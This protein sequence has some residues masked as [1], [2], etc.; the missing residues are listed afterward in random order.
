EFTVPTL[1]SQPL[2]I[3]AGP[4]GNLW[5][6]EH[7]SNRIGRG[8][9]AGAVNEFLLLNAGGQPTGITAG[10]DG[11]LWFTVFAGNKVARSNTR[12]GITAEFPGPTAG[13]QP[14]GIT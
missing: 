9:P 1:N 2:G 10:P 4:D 3:T 8:T 6:T 12:G 11:N 5:F 7:N 14:A 13:S